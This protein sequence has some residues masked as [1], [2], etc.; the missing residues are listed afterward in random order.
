MLRTVLARQNPIRTDV[1]TPVTPHDLADAMRRTQLVSAPYLDAVIAEADRFPDAASLATRLVELNVL[2]QFQAKIT[3]QGNIDALVFGPYRVLEQ[4]GEGGMGNVYKA[5]QPRLNRLVALKTIR[6]DLLAK[7][8]NAIRRFNREAQAI[9]Q[10]RHPNVVILYDA[11][12]VNGV[13]Y[14]AMEY[15]DGIDLS[16]M[17]GEQG[18]L[19]IPLAC[20]YIRQ[21]AM[22]LQHAYEAGLIHRD[23]KP[24]NL[25]VTRAVPTRLGSGTPAPGFSGTMPSATSVVKILDMGVARLAESLDDDDRSTTTLTQQGALIGTPDFIAPEQA[26]DASRAD[27]RADIY[28]LGCSFYYLLTGLVPFPDGTAIEKLLKHQLDPPVPVE[29]LRRQVPAAVLK[30]VSRMMAKDP[31][32]RHQTPQEVVDEL[33]TALALL[34]IQ[35]VA[36]QVEAQVAPA[37]ARKGYIDDWQ[38]PPPSLADPDVIL[39]K[40]LTRKSEARLPSTVLDRVVIPARRTARL[41]GHTGYVTALA[42]A[43]D[44]KHLA[45]GGLDGA[46]LVWNL[47]GVRADEE[48]VIDG[49]LGEVQ[50][51]AFSPTE[52][53][54]FGCSSVGDHRL[55]RW[56]YAERNSSRGLAWVPGESNGVHALAVSPDGKKFAASVGPA[57]QV[58][59]VNGLDLRRIGKVKGH[60]GILKAVALAPD[61][62]RLAC[63]GEDGRISVW[64]S[65]WLRNMLVACMAGH[66]DAVTALAYSPDGQALASASYDRTIRVWG[67]D[68]DASKPRVTFQGHQRTIRLI[69]FVRSGTQLISVGDGSQV[70]LWD[71]TTQRQVAE[72]SFDNGITSSLAVSPDGR[73]LAV[74]DSTGQVHLFSLEPMLPAGLSS[75]DAGN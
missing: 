34:G 14:L 25:L 20:N 12:E 19:P 46:L 59:A 53:Y 27:I 16:R 4:I 58:W 3:L 33:S 65:G 28:S 61:G 42:F 66:A 5:W 48:A 62:K 1:M 45:T 2:S 49:G 70:I 23:I 41:G 40:T 75:T 73:R 64:E 18:P 55:W 44:G 29:S 9:A 21:A 32:A 15:I 11:D 63:S 50:L 60:G 35:P 13:H 8:G 57:V 54:L 26:R 30:I 31:G 37:P 22:G 47:T 69:Q 67:A 7:Q 71:L 17:V 52:P 68:T 38:P 39:P 56:N 36:K 24:S 6:S 74:G 72:W 10:L 51:L 43:P